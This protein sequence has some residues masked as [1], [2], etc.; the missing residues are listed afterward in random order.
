[1]I[2]FTDL[3]KSPSLHGERVGRGLM[4]E[5]EGEGWE[6]GRRVQREVRGE[7]EASI[8]K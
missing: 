3:L 8:G 2:I 6:V 5:L 7:L 4:G 1:M